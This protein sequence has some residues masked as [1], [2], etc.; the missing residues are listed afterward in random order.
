[1]ALTGSTL[2]NGGFL[3]TFDANTGNITVANVISG[4]GGLT[5]TSSGTLTLSGNNSYSGATSVNA[6]TLAVTAN[7]ALGTN[8]AGTT[9]ASGATLDLQN[10]TYST[11]EAI[12][13]NGGTIATSTGTS[14]FAGGVTL[15]ADS[16]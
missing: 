1:L 8:A 12:T 9:I 2:T 4:T 3:S 5:K 7:N 6:G 10:V 13:N 11:T 16:I 14:S 15:G